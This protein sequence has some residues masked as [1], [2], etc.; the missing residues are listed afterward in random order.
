MMEALY[1]IVL[2]GIL[3]RVPRGGPDQPWWRVTFGIERAHGA[4]VWAIASGIMLSVAAGLW[5][6]APAVALALWLG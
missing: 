6:A 4:R 5:W 1:A 3:Y 2:S